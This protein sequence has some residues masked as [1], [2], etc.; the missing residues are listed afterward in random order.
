MS[1]I[2]PLSP[3]LSLFIW[4]GL[5]SLPCQTRASSSPLIRSIAIQGNTRTHPQVI[6]REFLFALGDSLDLERI[7]ETERNLRRLL[8]LGQ[9]KIQVRNSEDG[10]DL[11]VQVE[12]LYSRALSPLFSGDLDELSYGLVALDYNFSG[13][14]QI[15]RITLDHQAVSG[16]SG[17]LDYRIPRLVDDSHDLAVTLGIASE[18]H[19]VLLA[20][21]HPFYTLADPRSYGISLF[22]QE[23]IQ[24]LYTDRIL[25]ERYTDR[26]D[27]GS[28]WYS[29]SFGKAIKYRPSFRLSL[30]ERSFE[31]TPPSTYAP[32]DSLTV[33]DFEPSPPFTYAPQGRR[34]VIPS[35]GFLIWRPRY[36]ETRFLHALGPVED[37]QTGSWTSLRLGL[38][39]QFFASDRSFAL[40]QV[41][42]S[43]RLKLYPK[44]YLFGTLFLSARQQRDG[45]Y[46]L[47]THF[48]CLAY[49]RILSIHSLAFRLRWEALHRPEDATQ[50]LLGLNQGLRGYAPRRFDG[51]RRVLFNLEA[52]PTFYRHPLYVLAGAFFLDGGTTWTPSHTSP[53]LNLSLGLGA[54]IGLPRV[55]NTPILRVDLAYGWNDRNPQLSFGIGQYF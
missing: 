24:R 37:L 45:F 3:L 40:Y 17:T 7:A 2:L 49:A 19:D 48:E 31:P 46:H 51:T 34:R 47:F 52:R 12:D 26:L 5:L 13:R 1:R 8:F 20:L 23:E 15:A 35:I 50:L 55:Y 33:R 6:S 14:G 54:R 25:S 42:L 11:L 27:G 38:S 39:H 32:Q 30:T 16:N 44:G 41:Q 36:E 10:V 9:V 29:H 4:F 21:S 22:S 43:P 53:E 28:F 18:G